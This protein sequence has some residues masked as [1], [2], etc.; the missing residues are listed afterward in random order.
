MLQML[1]KFDY[2]K[3]SFK[4]PEIELHKKTIRF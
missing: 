4:M 3:L 2:K 1:E